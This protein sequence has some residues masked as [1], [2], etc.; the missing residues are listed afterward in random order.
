MAQTAAQKLLAAAQAQIAK[1]QAAIAAATPT[2]QRVDT[3][4]LAGIAA[5]SAAPIQQTDQQIADEKWAT[6]VLA[7]G[8]TQAQIDALRGAYDTAA[9]IRNNFPGIGSQVIDGQVVTGPTTT[10][11]IIP[12]KTGDT[13]TEPPGKPGNGWVWDG[14]KWVKPSMPQD[15]KTYTWDDNTGWVVS[16]INTSVTTTAQVDSIAAIT[17]LLSSYGLGGLGASITAAVM[18]GYSADTI[19][20]IMQDP[21]SNDPLAVAFQTRFPANKARLAAG[22]AVLSAAEYLAAERTYAQV[23]Q[24]YG[25]AN[26]ATRDIMNSFLIND[27]SAAEVSDRV[28]LAVNRVQ[29]AD[30]DTKAALATYYPMLNQADIVSA[31]LNPKDA[32]PALQRKVQTAEIGGAALA[33]KLTTGLEATSGASNLYSNVTTG[34][35]GASELAALGVTQAQARA[36]YAAV[37]DITPRAEFLSSISGGQDYTR[38]QAEQEQFQQLASAKRA[39]Q[40]LT[41]EEQA[42]FGGS[43]GT[44]KGAFSTGYLSKQSSAGAF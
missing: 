1:T 5:A 7:S 15:G 37:A 6:K 11:T 2:P 8:S 4:T 32:L 12:K 9:L 13:T 44:S 25:M 33:Q 43:S 3:T 17:A 31:M 42:R 20:L 24:S 39:R 22:K 10:T 18:K 38:L 40:A 21:N 16:Q 28:S 29:N 30:A 19:N 41:A 27:V 23:F 26:L 34:A 35:M 36:G 14:T